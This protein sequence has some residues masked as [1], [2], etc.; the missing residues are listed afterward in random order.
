MSVMITHDRW[1]DL[2]AEERRRLEQILP[3]LTLEQWAA[4]TLCDDW[5]VR[6]V[7]AHLTGTAAAAASVREQ[8]R[9]Q[10]HASSEKGTG[11]QLDA[12]NALQVRERAHLELDELRSQFTEAS[13]AALVR[14]QETPAVVRALR[15]PFP[16]PLGWASLG[17]LIDVVY[18]RDAWMHR[19]DI[20]DAVGRTPELTA[21]H[22]AVIL[23]D[24]ARVW[25]RRSG[26]EGIVLT[27]PIGMTLGNPGPTSPAYDG[28]TF[29]RA[30]SGRGSLPGIRDDLVLF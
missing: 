19:L 30:L 9:Q 26:T 14:R 10:R 28:I 3:A 20:C 11:T 6:E 7:V 5:T 15:F 29:A 8:L 16:A 22:D 17:F 21:A 18:T 25:L 13:L 1:M 12:V 27:G 4:P 23:A 24:A 2:A